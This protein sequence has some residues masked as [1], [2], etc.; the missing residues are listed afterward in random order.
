MS[1]RRSGRLT[2]I[3]LACGVVGPLLFIVVFL[4]EGATRPGYSPW[5]NYVS[6]L[7]LS[8]QGWQQIANFLM[9]GL[10][11]IAFGVGLR[12]AWRPGPASVWGPLLVGLFGL[13]L[14]IAG[15]FPTDPARGYPPGAPLIGGVQSWHGAIHGVNAAVLFLLI[16]P[17]TCFAVAWRFARQPEDHG[18]ATY[19]RTVGVLNLASFV[20]GTISG[21]LNEHGIPA[22]P[23][24]VFQRFQLILVW[25]WLASIAFR[26]GAETRRS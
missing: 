20:V 16:V 6:E 10:L 11:V 9:C 25:T 13:S 23:T 8:N 4:I 24:G 21:V 2:Q 5:R 15:V 3:L 17:A 19:S 18:W 1:S 26:V 12:R 14:V 22:A 7:A